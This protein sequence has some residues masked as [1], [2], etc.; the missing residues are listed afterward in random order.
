M[1]IRAYLTRRRAGRR[2]GV[3][4]HVRSQRECSVRD[5]MSHDHEIVRE[6]CACSHE[7]CECRQEEDRRHEQ[8]SSG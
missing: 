2:I 3:A 6:S 5:E 7:R 1:L 8:E 4:E